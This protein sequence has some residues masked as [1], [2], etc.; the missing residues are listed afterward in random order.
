MMR[1]TILLLVTLLSI[2][3]VLAASPII[4]VNEY[5]VIDSNNYGDNLSLGNGD[6]VSANISVTDSDGINDIRRTFLLWDNSS[7]DCNAQVY[8]QN[9]T[10]YLCLLTVTPAM[11]HITDVYVHSHSVDGDDQILLGNF[12]FKGR[13]FPVHPITC[14]IRDIQRRKNVCEN[15]VIYK[16]RTRRVCEFVDVNGITKRV[17]HKEEYQAPVNKRVCHIET[18][19]IQKN[20][21]STKL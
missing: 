10:N 2:T 4:T 6:Q 8:T 7:V 5:H 17:C 19:T 15:E 16:T 21:C 3:T 11:D 14:T 20:V 12:D 18:Y 13:Q 1:K 9:T